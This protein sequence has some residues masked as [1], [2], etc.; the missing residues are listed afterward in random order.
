MPG[1]ELVYD[2]CGG[3]EALGAWG[4]WVMKVQAHCHPFGLWSIATYREVIV[5]FGY[6]DFSLPCSLQGYRFASLRRDL[7]FHGVGVVVRKVQTCFSLD[8]SRGRK[9][10]PF[11]QPP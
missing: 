8:A 4:E 10:S 5:V 7:F 11:A 6:S 3:S 2:K 1:P 9:A